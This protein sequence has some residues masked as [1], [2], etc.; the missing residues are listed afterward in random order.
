MERLK[1]ATVWL[2]GCS[3]CHMSFLDLDEWL[4]DLAAMADIVYTP[5]ADVKQYPEGVDAVLVEGAVA[6][7]ENLEFIRKVRQRSRLLISFGD[8]AITGN[9]TALRNLVELP[10]AFQHSPDVQ[11]SPL[12][13][14]R[15]SYLELPDVDA[16]LPADAGIVPILLD[17]VRPV[18]E[19]VPVDFYLPGCPPPAARIRAVLES[20]LAGKTPSLT[21]KDIRFG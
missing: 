4:I 10:R 2:G 15:R 17:R 13:V 5:L 18:H 14:L 20:V 16:Q 21:G 3:G 8:C 6:N 1:L 19:I 9:V 11:Q 12:E 7:E